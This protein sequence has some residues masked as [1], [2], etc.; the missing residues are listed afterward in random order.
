MEIFS[1]LKNK[2]MWYLGLTYNLLVL[3][4]RQHNNVLAL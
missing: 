2:Q 1:Y 4:N 3:Q